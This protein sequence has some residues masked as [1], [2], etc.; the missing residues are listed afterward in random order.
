MAQVLQIQAQLI[1]SPI[2]SSVVDPNLIAVKLIGACADHANVRQ[3]A[4]IF[5]HLANPN[6]FAH[7]ATL[8][9][10]A[11]NSHWFHAIQFF[12]H[13]VSSPNAPNPD[14]FTFTS[15]LK[16]CAGLAHVVNGQKIHA[17]VTKQGF[18]SNLFVRNSLIDMYFKAGYLLIARHL[19]DEM[20]VRDVVSWNT[21]VSGYCLCGCADDARWVFD[22][23]REKNSFLGR[24]Y[25]QNEK[26]SDAIEVFRMMQQF[27]GVVPND[28]TLVSVL[29]AC[30]HLG[31]LDL[32]SGL[33]DLSVG[34]GWPWACSWGM[35][36]QI[37]EAF[38][39]FYEMLDCGVK[40]NDVV[41]MGLLTACTHAGRAGELDKAE[42]MISSMPMKPNVIIWGALLGG[43]RIYRDSGR[44]Q[45]VVQH[46][47]ELD[48]D[49]SGSYVYLPMLFFNGWV[50]TKT[51]LVVHSIDEEEKEDALSIHSEKLAIAF[52]L[53]STS[54]GTTI[55]V[56]KNLR[57]CND[58][59]D[60]AK[61]ISGIVKREII[62]RDRSRF[63]HFKD[64]VCLAVTIGRKCEESSV[65]V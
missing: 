30:A 29:P 37:Y 32:G 53:I 52:G 43:C 50:Q 31:A 16:A 63:H 60:A 64:G 24:R 34:E 20:F 6:I 28:V 40:P 3:A 51:D 11:Q 8:K 38:G 58:C 13:Q 1:T 35:H 44:G 9:A 10:L 17:M 56:V 59:H 54:E 42:D 49:H 25:A 7:N 2:P 14:E 39:C 55:R 4:L 5:A 62:V 15:V 23:M 57:I 19:F 22:R 12:N 36:W 48:S 61:I 21:L 26:Y 41:F 45:R 46:I 27:G 47:L 65:G 18:E 33:M